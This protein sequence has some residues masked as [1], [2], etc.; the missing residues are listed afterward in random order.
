[1]VLKTSNSIAGKTSIY[2]IAG[3]AILGVVAAL[4]GS[5]VW[6]SR[7]SPSKAAGPL[8]NVTIATNTEYAG[9]CPILVAQ[10]QGYFENEGIN[11]AI[12]PYTTGK[13]ALD[14]A[15]QGQAN[16]ATVADVPIMFAVMNGQPL[17]IIATIFTAERDHGIVARKDKGIDTPAS[18]KGKRIG[19]TPGSS[20][21]FLLDAF[22][23]RQKLAAKD[24][25]VVGLK[26]EDLSGAMAQGTIDA[27]ATWEPFLGTLLAQL[28]GNGTIFYGEGVYDL[29]FNIAG[30]RDYVS[31]HPETM[32]K[33][34]KALVRGGRFC[35]ESPQAARE[36]IAKI[37]K[38]DA[39]KFNDL[40]PSFRF[41]VFLDQ[42]LVLALEDQTRWA[43]KNKLVGKGEIPNYLDYIYLDGLLAVAPAA[44]TVIH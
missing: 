24:V 40:W 10:K 36:I 9:S 4:A 21:H 2:A 3:L 12:Q 33:V 11:L 5:Y 18:L 25:T 1:M 31:S 13:R 35:K 30:N 44:V 42:G 8:E 39:M 34:L 43:I 17:S 7:T 28:A 32:K 22:L 37:M 6:M 41:N 20:G 29:L 14:A 19:V 16:L 23:N 38:T 26:P 27:A 15:L